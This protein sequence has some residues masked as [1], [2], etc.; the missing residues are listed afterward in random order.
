ML[1][2]KILTY[3]TLFISSVYLQIYNIEHAQ[4]GGREKHWLKFLVQVVGSIRA[5][6][7]NMSQPLFV[8]Y[9]I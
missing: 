2:H 5:L 8:H 9:S 3:T 4:M 7:I 1:L 6:K